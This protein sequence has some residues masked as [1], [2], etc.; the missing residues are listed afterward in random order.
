MHDT[1]DC[2][3]SLFAGAVALP[4]EERGAYLDR[5]CAGDPALR[6]RLLALLRAHDRAGNVIDR[7]VNGDPNQTAGYAA[8]SEQPGT[9]IAGRYKL[10]E[11]IGE[12]AWGR[13]GRPSRRHP[14]VAR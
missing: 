9:I 13:S 2:T 14:F 1:A 5:E 10:L 6:D 7:P 4:P 8:T 12:G 3:E 11:E